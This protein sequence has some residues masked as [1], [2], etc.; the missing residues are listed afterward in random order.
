M[1]SAS[2]RDG[3]MRRYNTSL[4]LRRVSVDAKASWNKINA[5]SRDGTL[6]ASLL[7]ALTRQQRRC[8]A[9]RNALC[10]VISQ[11]F[12][13]AGTSVARVRWTA[14]Y[15]RPSARGYSASSRDG[16]LCK[17]DRGRGG[18][19]CGL[20]G[21]FAHAHYRFRKRALLVPFRCDLIALILRG[22][23]Y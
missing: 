2:S 14:H 7:Q 8:N 16:A 6:Q 23:D 13:G 21:R 22:T 1:R 15:A 20:R 3:A 10:S 18:H 12:R 11:S 5:S 9:Y 17:R 4:P 19:F